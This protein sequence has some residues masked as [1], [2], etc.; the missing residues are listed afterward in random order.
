MRW[1]WQL[2]HMLLFWYAC[3][4]VSI[5]PRPLKFKIFDLGKK[6]FCFLL[7]LFCFVPNASYF[8]ASATTS[9][10]TFL[11]AT[12]YHKSRIYFSRPPD[13]GI[14]QY[15]PSQTFKRDFFNPSSRLCAFS[16]RRGKLLKGVPSWGSISP[17][18]IP[19]VDYIHLPALMI[20]P[21]YSNMYKKRG[22][23]PSHFDPTEFSD[24]KGIF[25]LQRLN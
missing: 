14:F 21:N 8:F 17:R 25:L 16:R 6:F 23:F 19:L 11:A 22:E 1:L 2:P 4:P 13:G 7:C 18:T 20:G 10:M 3:L 15:I 5:N 12:H 24:L 9:E